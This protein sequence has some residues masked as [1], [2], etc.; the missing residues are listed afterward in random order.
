MGKGNV[1]I[2]SLPKLLNVHIASQSQKQNKLS[3]MKN[4]FQQ[5]RNYFNCAI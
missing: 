5:D 4:D 1:L 2:I 3:G